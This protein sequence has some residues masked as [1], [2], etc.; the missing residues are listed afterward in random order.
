MSYH[1][2]DRWR[3]RGLT[4]RRASRRY[5]TATLLALTLMV[6]GT[7]FAHW[8]NA[9]RN[10]AFL[11]TRAEALEQAGQFADASRYWDFYLHLIP[12]DDA[13]FEQATLALARLGTPETRFEARD[14]LLQLLRKDP[15]NQAARVALIRLD[16]R[17]GERAEALREAET[18]SQVAGTDGA[19]W[20]LIGEAREANERAA[21]ALAAYRTALDA[22]PRALANQKRYL[23]LLARTE[24]G[25]EVEKGVTRMLEHNP[26]DPAALLLAYVTR[27]DAKLPNAADALESAVRS[28]PDDLDVL[29][30]ATGA[31]TDPARAAE[32][33]E[34]SSRIGPE[35][36]RVL[37]L[38]GRAAQS[39]G[40]EDAALAALERGF[41]ASGGSDPE[42]AWRLAEIRVDRG[43]RDRVEPLLSILIKAPGYR[44]LLL[45]LR[46]R[47]A[48]LDDNPRQAALDF[49]QALEWMDAN[50][51]K[52]GPVVVSDE[53]RYK[54]LLADA[55]AQIVQGRLDPALEDAKR[56]SQILPRESLPWAT[57]G[58]IEMALDNYSAAADA[59]QAA[60]DRPPTPPRAAVEL[61]RALLR[62]ELE[63]PGPSR[64]FA[65]YA[66]AVER[67]KRTCPDEPDL[68][69]L[70]GEYLAE[71]GD[72]D[73]AITLLKAGT[74]GHPRH[75]ALALAL[76]QAL[77]QAGRLDEAEERI[78]RTHKTFGPSD[79][80]VWLLALVQ[81]ARG[82]SAKAEKTLAAIAGRAN[83]PDRGEI[84]VALGNL[85]WA[86]H[87]ETLALERFR[88]AAATPLGAAALVNFLLAQDRLEETLV[89]IG[90]LRADNPAGI[91]WRWADCRLAARRLAARPAWALPILR[92][93]LES[94][95]KGAPGRWEVAEIAGLAAELE[96]H[97]DIAIAQYRVA[98]SRGPA[99]APLVDHAVDLLLRHHRVAEARE[100]LARLTRAGFADPRVARVPF[101]LQLAEGDVD[102]TMA[103]ARQ[104]AATWPDDVPK[105]IWYGDLL[106]AAGKSDEANQWLREVTA[107]F[108]SA[109]S[110]WVARALA[111]GDRG[112]D[113]ESLLA[114]IAAKAEVDNR[115]YLE[116]QCAS[117]LGDRAGAARRFA[118]AAELGPLAE[119]QWR[120]ILDV[121]ATEETPDRDQLAAK[122]KALFP[123]AFWLRRFD[124]ER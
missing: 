111:L 21:D 84:G 6:G 52:V 34:R 1:R 108:P 31:A 48:F 46:G 18:L 32:Y 72:L 35:D 114:E 67:A 85:A 69:L 93:H 71:T 109:A 14:K 62:I 27:R 9:P 101:R 115:T 95:R 103:E 37:L 100:I 120:T 41:A 80:L 19:L 83:D 3:K 113:H 116:A 39:K 44:P 13:A 29:L 11:K 47:M 66:K 56:A 75:P 25:A 79:S 26:T 55:A 16:L 36:P 117:A 90:R 53:A 92:T 124:P 15:N 122:A 77:I 7:A 104:Y 87:D 20:T 88:Q 59:W 30:M 28:A 107:S 2:N 89:E 78:A 38:V 94:M 110:A 97:D 22:D 12:E 112:A 8:V 60:L 123:D 45:Y 61:A 105:Q 10:A 98:L 121:L 64:S 23:A 68:A 119:Y 40:D 73:R 54:I 91:A 63:K 51:A 82:E 49:A 17:M 24:S 102:G 99:F 4:R 50:A 33:L 5:L 57:R 81:Q 106:R 70:E 58:G 65:E 118:R 76:C 86:R 96:G 42:F 74:Q 43:E